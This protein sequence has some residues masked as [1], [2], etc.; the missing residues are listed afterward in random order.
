MFRG[1]VFDMDGVIVDSHPLHKQAWRSFL[2]HLGK[3]VSESELAFIFEGRKRREI[4][5]HFLGELSESD[6]QLYGNK[7]DEFFRQASQDLKPITGSA[8]F[9]K[10]L[11]QS[12]LSLAVATSAS[13]QRAQWTLKQLELEDC[14]AVV[15][16]GDDVLAG[17]PDPAIYRLAAQ[18]LSLPASGLLAVEDSVS[19]I[20]SATTAGFGCIGVGSGDDAAPLINAGAVFVVPNL[21]SL[22]IQSLEQVFGPQNVSH[23]PASK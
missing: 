10:S 19:G 13:R 15:V 8:E 1:V 20:R 9:I 21:M 2:V 7:K 23:T 17:K 4:L 11:K 22:T 16:T 12:G 18:R 6:I 14:F 5:I 3:E